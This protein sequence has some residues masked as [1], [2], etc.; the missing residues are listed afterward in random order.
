M[1]DTSSQIEYAEWIKPR[2]CAEFDRAANALNTAASHQAEQDRMDTLLS[3]PSLKR[4][5]E[6]MAND[7]AGYF[8]E[9]WRE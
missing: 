3:S 6:V 8:I 7:E 5:N 9:R 4:N 1:T 2:V